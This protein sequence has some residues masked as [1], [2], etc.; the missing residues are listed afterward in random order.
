MPKLRNSNNNDGS[1]LG[2]AVG[3][4]KKGADVEVEVNWWPS[5]CPV[6]TPPPAHPHHPATETPADHH[7][8]WPWQPDNISK[9]CIFSFSLEALMETTNNKERSKDSRIS[10][11]SSKLQFF[12]YLEK[13]FQNVLH[14]KSKMECAPVVAVGAGLGSSAARHLW[15]R[16]AS[17]TRASTKHMQH[18]KNTIIFPKMSLPFH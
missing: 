14:C 5:Q 3:W 17:A 8:L 13:C 11:I 15:S 7:Q 18:E 10:S 1:P 2:A 4:S 9:Y 6:W 12:R 16:H